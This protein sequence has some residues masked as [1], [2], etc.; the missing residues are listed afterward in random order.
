MK[1][2][3]VLILTFLIIKVYSQDMQ[4]LNS[5]LDMETRISFLIDEMTLDEKIQEA[6]FFLD[7]IKK[8]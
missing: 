5:A 7:L 1:L 3:G 6:E 8:R 2:I 4:W